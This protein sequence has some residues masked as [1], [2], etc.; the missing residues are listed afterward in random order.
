[1]SETLLTPNERDNYFLSA[2]ATYEVHIYNEDAQVNWEIP[3][4]ANSYS[5][6]SEFLNNEVKYVLAQVKREQSLPFNEDGLA[7]GM[8]NSG[9]SFVKS[10]DGENNDVFKITSSNLDQLSVYL[11]D[12]NL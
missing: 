7:S 12:E 6:E 8:I 3:S 1:D 11:A 9:I 5:C 4:S 10:D 2:N